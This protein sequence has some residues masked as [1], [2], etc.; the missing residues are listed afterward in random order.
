MIY[1]DITRVVTVSDYISFLDAAS[2]PRDPKLR[3]PMEK[4]LAKKA[5]AV[6]AL[7]RK[8]MAVMV[9]QPVPVCIMI[10]NVL[11]VALRKAARRTLDELSSTHRGWVQPESVKR[12]AKDLET[13]L[14]WEALAPSPVKVATAPAKEE[15]SANADEK[16]YGDMTEEEFDDYVRENGLGFLSADAAASSDET[17][18][19]TPV[20]PRTAWEGGLEPASSYRTMKPLPVGEVEE[21]DVDDALSALYE[22]AA[23]RRGRY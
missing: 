11:R 14:D 21:L 2:I 13:A 10:D 20:G 15:P 7:S 18:G 23:A 4:R 16:F 19:L 1:S 3:T 9:F 6:L 12:A 17:Q 22:Q 5:V 8:A